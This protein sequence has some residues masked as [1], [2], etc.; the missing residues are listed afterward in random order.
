[1]GCGCGKKKAAG[2]TVGNTAIRTAV[3]QVVKDGQ[4]VSEFST[5][6]EARKAAAEAGGRVRISSRAGA[7]A[8]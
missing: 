1:M 6:Q 7:A 2:Q 4:T 5:P 3:Y 8:V